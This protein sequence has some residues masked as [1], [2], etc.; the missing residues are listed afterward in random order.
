MNASTAAQ[1]A[2]ATSAASI[3]AAASASAPAE[4]HRP[5]ATMQ[6]V[7]QRRYAEPEAMTL[8]T[9]E[10]PEPAADEV[11]IEVRAA[12]VDR[13][14]WHLVTGHPM[15][16]RLMG[17]GFRRP[18]NPTP[19]N[20]VSGVVVGVG[21]E[22]TRF[23][24]GDEVFG[25]TDSGYAE[26][27]VAKERA[28]VTKP[29]DLG[30]AEAATVIQSALPAQIAVD[31]IAKV[32][33]GQRVLVLGASG[34][35]GSFAV[36]LAKAAGAT[37]AAVGSAAKADLMR[38]L[39]ADTVIAYETTDVTTEDAT[40]DAI[41]DIGG[42]L[43]VYRLRRI[44]APEGTLVIVGGEGGGT[45]TGG[46]GRQLRAAALNPFIRQTLAFFV[47]QPSPEN[48]ARLRERLVA[49]DF[50]SAVTRTYPLAE[51]PAA[52]ADIAAGRIAGKA[53]VIVR[54]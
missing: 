36:Q 31:D 19:G 10:R 50:R 8:E 40:Y 39:G 42:R 20:E 29:A 11:L 18:S 1:A 33:A 51:A 24:L 13:G 15:I 30:F 23:S 54:D 6:A 14:Q 52:V 28:L 35:V 12:G 3:A 45:V 17:F 44:L 47:S 49:G 41:I 34:G 48:I 22:V 53:A 5:A 27:A 32:S 26:Y 7:V 38:D 21:A 25:V 16:M 2:A 46:I 43:P 9:V 4:P 37:V